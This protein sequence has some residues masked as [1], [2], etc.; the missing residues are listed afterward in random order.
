MEH[1]ITRFV[2]ALRE[3]GVRVSPGESLDAVQALTF[4]GLSERKSVRSLL[5]LTLVKTANELPVF[6]EVF[7][8]FFSQGA[9]DPVE[10]EMTDLM[11]AFIH[12]VEGSLHKSNVQNPHDDDDEKVNLLLDEE[13]TA[14]DLEDLLGIEETDNDSEGPE[15]KV[16]LDGFRG[17]MNAPSPSDYF[18]QSLPSVAFHQ[19]GK[20]SQHVP[21]SLEEISAMQ[22]VV[23]RM[24]V[25]IRKD[26]KR[27]KEKENRGRLHVVRTIQKNYRHGMVPFLLAL[28]RKRKEK[29]RLVVLC[30]VSYSV[31]HATRFMLLLLHT[32][33]N[34][35]MDVRSF[36]FNND[37]VEITDRLR[38]LP[39][40][41]LLETIDKGDIVNLDD[42]SDYGNVLVTFKKNFLEGLSGKPAIIIMGDARNNYNEAENWALEE[43][44]EKAG[45]ML[46]LSP[47]ER[48]LWGRGDCLMELYGSYCDSVEVVKSADDLSLVVE[49]LF[50]TL[51]DHNDTRTWKGRRPE[52]Q[53]AKDRDPSN[54]YARPGNDA[55]PAF[56]PNVRRSW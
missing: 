8:R 54:Y 42:N 41:S 7:D 20:S 28:R 32:L 40:N 34:R 24:L 51:Y 55:L 1:I 2:C 25:R 23:F 52:I 4:A 35:L 29:P 27:M 30:D 6:E 36:I 33:Q 12:V 46:W 14:E 18:M 44:R 9:N 50:F 56:D 10:Y 17:K 43:L 39:V 53:D 16:Q 11:G 26:V 48:D 37:I 31:S 22:E 21:F 19:A 15:I 47:E 3:R 5:R 38:N 13:V 49:K 45:Y